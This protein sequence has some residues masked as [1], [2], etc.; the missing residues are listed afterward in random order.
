MKIITIAAAALLAFG[1]GSALAQQ[2]KKAKAEKKVTV[3]A[4][5]VDAVI[6]AGLPAFP[7]PPEEW[8]PRLTPDETMKVCAATHNSPP[9]AQFQAIEKAEKAK[10]QYPAD[11]NYM[12][13]WKKGERIAQ[14]GYG[15]RF[16]D[17]P[18]RNPNGGNCY[19]C[20]QLSQAEISYGTI[21]PSLLGYGKLRDFKESEIKAAYEK[22]YDSHA[23]FPCSLMPR[24][25]ANKVLSMDQIKDLVALLMAKD[26]P[27]NK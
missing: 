21:G 14:S 8:Q 15:L 11:N 18:A 16:T 5:K 6:K 19:G 12:G 4:A 22:I 26:S 3:S 24:F 23:S 1:T 10:I 7:A 20:H 13:D 25:G 9:K 27:V 2:Q 17:Y